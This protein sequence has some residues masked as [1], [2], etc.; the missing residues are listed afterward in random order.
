MLIGPGC[1]VLRAS[2]G[3]VGA[4]RVPLALAGVVILVS[5]SPAGSR[6]ATCGAI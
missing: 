4:V 6:L 2:S 3:R 5:T 1:S